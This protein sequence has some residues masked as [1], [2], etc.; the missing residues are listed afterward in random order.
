[1]QRPD[2]EVA[3]SEESK[4]RFFVALDRG[5][6]VRSR[7][8]PRFVAPMLPISQRP[9]DVQS[10]TVPGHWEGDLIV[11]ADGRSAIATLVERTSRYLL[12]V[13]LDRD[14]SAA[15][16]RKALVAAFSDIPP[17]LRLSL[18]WDQGAEMAE[19][20][21][22][23]MATNVRVY[24]CD[25]A[26]PWQRGTNENTNGLVREFFPKGSDLA[27]HD[28][29]QLQHV[30]DQLNKRPRRALDWATPHEHF[31]SLLAC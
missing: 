20:H 5:G 3:L 14:R 26:S 18:T 24:F 8:T 12:L 23:T 9:H 25:A 30:A 6:T 28:A 22:L 2:L 15:G 31:T 1:L 21:A 29:E 27:R 13:H 4:R 7:R 19:H 10:R 16:V 17:S 11:G